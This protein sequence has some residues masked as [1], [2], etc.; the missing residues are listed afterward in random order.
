MINT[1]GVSVSIVILTYNE[2]KNI[3]I[4]LKSVYDWADEIFIVDSYSTDKTLKR[5]REYTDKIYQNKFE[6]Y[7]NQRNWALDNLPFSN[8]W[9]FFLDA[10]ERPSDELKSEISN[11]FA[12]TLPEVNGFYIKRKFIFLDKWIKHGGYYPVWIL[13][14]F[15]HK[16]AR[17]QEKEIDEDFMVKGNTE[18]LQHDIIHEDNRGITFWINRHNK[19]ATIDAIKQTK[20]NEPK[21]GVS[22]FTTNTSFL[23]KKRFIKRH[24]WSYFPIFFRPCIYFLYRYI[25]RGG[26]LEGMPGLVYHF[27]HGFWYRFLVDVKIYEYKKFN[28]L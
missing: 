11:I 6:G 26:F 8:E 19:Y 2:E 4:C 24:I 28:R 23:E 7:P 10:D 21:M 27:L 13:R 15:K 14:L 3:E 5:A 18:N 22:D 12:A 1:K 16:L 9:I 20:F 17:C 25:L